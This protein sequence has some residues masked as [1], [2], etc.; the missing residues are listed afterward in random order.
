MVIEKMSAGAEEP[1]EERDSG[2]H[3]L[4]VIE[5]SGKDLQGA[6]HLSVVVYLPIHCRRKVFG[7]H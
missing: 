5:M 7:C 6:V 4:W 1:E 3:V 2:E